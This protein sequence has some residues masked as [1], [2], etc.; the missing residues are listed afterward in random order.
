M[1][2]TSACLALTYSFLRLPHEHAVPRSEY[3]VNMQ[4]ISRDKSK[5][6]KGKVHPRTGLKSPDGE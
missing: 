3:T 1:Q 6:D 4:H 5:Q 2:M